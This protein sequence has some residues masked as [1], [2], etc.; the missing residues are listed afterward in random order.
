[1]QTIINSCMHFMYIVFVILIVVLIDFLVQIKLVGIHSSSK[2]YSDIKTARNID[3]SN[4]ISTVPIHIS[5]N[6]WIFKYR[7]LLTMKQ[8]N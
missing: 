2:M 5:V 6:N 3:N 7:K 8:A 4:S 1:M